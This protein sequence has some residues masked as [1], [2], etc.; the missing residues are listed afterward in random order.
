MGIDA[1]V[2]QRHLVNSLTSEPA[3]SGAFAKCSQYYQFPLKL[4]WNHYPHLA[5]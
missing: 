4:R 3:D 1:G 2:S 5:F